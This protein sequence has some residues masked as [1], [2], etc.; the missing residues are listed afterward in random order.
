M[1][2]SLLLCSVVLLALGGYAGAAYS[3][4]GSTTP[5]GA[6]W[7]L[8]RRAATVPETVAVSRSRPGKINLRVKQIAP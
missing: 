6:R 2:N 7:P 1:K 3:Y 4:E 8:T 5:S